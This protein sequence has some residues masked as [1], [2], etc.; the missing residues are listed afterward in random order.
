MAAACRVRFDSRARPG[1]RRP[2]VA[3]RDTAPV[4]G[5]GAKGGAGGRG[6]GG[7]TVLRTL[8]HGALTAADGGSNTVTARSAVAAAVVEGEAASSDAALLGR[9]RGDRVLGAAAAATAATGSL[10]GCASARCKCCGVVIPLVLHDLFDL[11]KTRRGVLCRGVLCRVWRDKGRERA[12]RFAP[13]RPASAPPH[14]PP[15][16][17][18]PHLAQLAL[19]LALLLVSLAR[20]QPN[21]GPPLCRLGRRAAG[22]QGGSGGRRGGV[23]AAR[24]W[25]GHSRRTAP[26]RQPRRS[27]HATASPAHLVLVP[28]GL[29]VE[30]APSEALQEEHAPQVV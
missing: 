12:G 11:Q 18:P 21:L 20:L 8:G 28:L 13:P 15:W 3:R 2:F 23:R 25:R 30:V 6:G 9:Q 16:P 24:A 14:L 1:V 7:G 22:L 26:A 29:A 17:A 19:Q 5:E 27:M 4:N 10:L